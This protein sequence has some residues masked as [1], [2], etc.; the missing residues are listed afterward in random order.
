MV[1]LKSYLKPGLTLSSEVTGLYFGNIE[2]RW[3]NISL[4]TALAT[5]TVDG[6]Q[7]K[8]TAHYSCY[9]LEGIKSIFLIIWIF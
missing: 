5:R 7:R 6:I 9:Y 2:N 8:P 3:R 1:S 4:T